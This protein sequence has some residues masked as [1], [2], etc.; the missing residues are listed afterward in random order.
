MKNTARDAE[1]FHVSPADFA[2]KVDL[3]PKNY[4]KEEIK[5]YFERFSGMFQKEVSVVDVIHVY[6]IRPLMKVT[7]RVNKLK[8]IKSY[9]NSRLE[10]GMSEEEARKHKFICI[11]KRKYPSLSTLDQRILKL[12]MKQSKLMHERDAKHTTSTAFVI[13]RSMLDCRRITELMN[14]DIINRMRQMLGK[15]KSRAS[16]FMDNALIS[17]APEPDDIY[18]INMKVSTFSRFTVKVL[19]YI[20]LIVALL[21]SLFFLFEINEY[22]EHNQS[23]LVTF[24]LSLFVMFYNQVLSVLIQVLT[25]FEMHA[26]WSDYQSSLTNK[27]CLFLCV[28]TV[29]LPLY[30]H[31]YSQNWY[32]DGGLAEDIFWLS[33]IN[34][35][36]PNI[37]YALDIPHLLKV[38]RKKLIERKAAKEA[39]LKMN[40][41][42]AN[43]LYE[44]PELDLSYR[45]AQVVKTYMLCMSYAPIVPVIIPVCIAGLILEYWIVK[46]KLLRIHKKPRN[47]GTEIFKDISLW[48]SLG[49]FAHAVM[50]FYLYRKEQNAW[51][52]MTVF[53]LGLSFQFLFLPTK[54]LVNSYRK[55]SSYEL[56]KDL[57]KD[58]ESSDNYHKQLPLFP[59]DYL[60]ANPVTED[61]GWLAWLASFF[62]HEMDEGRKLEIKS[63]IQ[64]VSA[65]TEEQKLQNWTKYYRAPP[66]IRREL[67][68]PYHEQLNQFLLPGSLTSRTSRGRP[69]T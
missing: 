10:G 60:R 28:N 37:M 36:V 29:Y 7:N 49:I 45:S 42:D 55:I 35:I 17:R 20:L 58:D 13:L 69:S 11:C 3:L 21:F 53:Y 2:I 64:G 52:N 1:A 33:V 4:D 19:I 23:K 47:Y 30:I 51:V 32:K 27:L 22:Q 54:S 59:T 61:E 8:A 46:Y 31:S 41:A 34:A 63:I 57:Y 12:V 38:V 40:Q 25:K 9:I 48:I 65:R 16:H 5:K 26:T 14:H 68:R 6:D 24:S 15:V 39:T 43:K 50:T 56:L 62:A 44:G 67:P 66:G 18:W